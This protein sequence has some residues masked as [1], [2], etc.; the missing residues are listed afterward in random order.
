MDVYSAI[1][2]FLLKLTVSHKNKASNPGVH[3]KKASDK[4]FSKKIFLSVNL[5]EKFSQ[6]NRKKSLISYNSIRIFY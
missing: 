5:I 1:D 4:I 6:L 2:K 3:S